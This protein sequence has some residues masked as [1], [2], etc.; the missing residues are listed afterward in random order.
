[1]TTSLNHS[2]RV[3][4]IAMLLTLLTTWPAVGTA[5]GQTT[6]AN[7]DVVAAVLDSVSQRRDASWN[8]A[9]RIW[10]AAEPGYQETK[11]S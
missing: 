11:S 4:P 3:L 7:D 10:N 6:P 9:L 2:V 8:T 1:M 5:A